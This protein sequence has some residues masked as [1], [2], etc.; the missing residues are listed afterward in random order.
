MNMSY[1]KLAKE[2]GSFSDEQLDMSVTVYVP[3]VNE[4]YPIDQVGVNTRPNQ[5]DVLDGGH[6]VL[7][8]P[9]DENA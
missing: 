2:I 8:I 3:G 6:P 1:R 5:T 9:D 7:C 4:Y